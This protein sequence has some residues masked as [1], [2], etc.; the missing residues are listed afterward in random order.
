MTTIGRSV[1]T[2]LNIIFQRL[3]II[4]Y[5]LFISVFWVVR[6]KLVATSLI[7]FYQNDSLALILICGYED[8]KDVEGVKVVNKEFK[9]N[10]SHYLDASTVAH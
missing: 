6:G 10:H 4:I 3:N 2:N 8:E 1:T 9:T 5:A 7:L